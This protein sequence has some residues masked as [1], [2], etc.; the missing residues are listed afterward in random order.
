MPE[1]RIAIAT[2]VTAPEGTA[3]DDAGR[4]LLLPGGETLSPWL[5]LEL[6]EDRDLTCDELLALGVEEALDIDRSIEPA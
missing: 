5:A 2:I 6:D 1:F 4:R 3:V